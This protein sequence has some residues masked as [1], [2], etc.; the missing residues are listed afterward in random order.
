MLVDICR[1]T[2]T[3]ANSARLRRAGVTKTPTDIKGWMANVE[4]AKVRVSPPRCQSV[5]SGPRPSSL[6]L[7][8]LLIWVLTKQR[9]CHHRP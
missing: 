3:W 9:A 2:V 4:R 1:V 8:W 5:V 7:L 6:S